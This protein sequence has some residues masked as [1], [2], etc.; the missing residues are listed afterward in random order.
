MTWGRGRYRAAEP[1][2]TCL[3]TG[4]QLK[5]YSWGLSTSLSSAL[6]PKTHFWLA[7]VIATWATHAPCFLWIF[8][9]APYIERL[10]GNKALSGAL[11]AMTAA[12]SGVILNVSLWFALHTLF[13]RVQEHRFGPFQ[14]DGPVWRTLSLPTLILA[15]VAGLALLHFKLSTLPMLALSTG[16]GLAYVFLTQNL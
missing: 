4:D 14:L 3:V 2:P 16:L 8:L 13:G 9:G 7:S 10:R 6:T 15:V 12:L 1:P 5:V 11:T